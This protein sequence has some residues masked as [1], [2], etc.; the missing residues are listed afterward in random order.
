MFNSVLPRVEKGHGAAWGKGDFCSRNIILRA[1]SCAELFS[2]GTLHK[3][4][5][6]YP[7]FEM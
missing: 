2:E 4:W 6:T 3:L 1:L 7:M 5:A